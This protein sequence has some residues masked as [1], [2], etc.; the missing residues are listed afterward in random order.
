M[1]SLTVR[2]DLEEAFP[3]QSLHRPDTLV[4]LFFGQG[5][6]QIRRD[7][8]RTMLRDDPFNVANIEDLYRLEEPGRFFLTV[9]SKKTYKRLQGSTHTTKQG[10]RVTI[11][12]LGKERQPIFLEWV[13]PAMT[14]KAVLQIA[15]RLSQP[16]VQ[17]TAEPTEKGGDRWTVITAPREDLPHYV[18]LQLTDS[19]KGITHK[20]LVLKPGRKRCYPRESGIQ[21]NSEKQV[22]DQPP[23]SPDPKM[24]CDSTKPKPTTR[25]RAKDKLPRRVLVDEAWKSCK[26]GKWCRMD[27]DGC[28]ADHRFADF[29]SVEFVPIPWENYKL[30]PGEAH[31][32][33]FLKTIV[34]AAEFADITDFA[35]YGEV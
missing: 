17:P 28:H 16:D 8:V 34:G 7:E 33:D 13:P 15:A 26:A 9:G 6:H 18:D 29:P 2:M 10:I 11:D 1:S 14:Q 31:L 5:S 20:I 22:S 30:K 3:A 32:R 23:A 12:P 24:S 27:Q 25:A 19:D 4:V 21:E 35:A